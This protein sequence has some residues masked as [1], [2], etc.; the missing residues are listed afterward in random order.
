MIKVTIHETDRGIESVCVTGHAGSNEK[1]KDLVCAGVSAITIGIAN[2]LANKKFLEEH[3][4]IDIK[5][6]FMQVRVTQSSHD[7]Q[8]ILETFVISLQTVEESYKQY[9][10]ILKTED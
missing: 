8:L 9:I 2:A 10:Q 3:G 4:T 7:I 1:G 6:G 5:E